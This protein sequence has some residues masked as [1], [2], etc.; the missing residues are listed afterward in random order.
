MIVIPAIDLKDGQC[1]RLKQGDLSDSTVFSD[2]PRET[3]ARWVDAGS[4]RLHIVDLN[5]AVQGRPVNAAAIDAIVDGFPELDIQIGGGIRDAHT[6]GAYLERGVRWVIVGT[7]AVRD[8][9][10]VTAL[11]REFPGHIIVGLDARDGAVATDGW[12]EVS[13]IDVRDLARQFSDSGVSAIVYTDIARDGML[14][15]ANVAATRALA[16]VTDIPV[17][18]SGGVRDLGDIE[19]LCQRDAGAS[20]IH[21]VI[22]GRSIYEGTLNLAQAQALA[23]RLSGENSSPVGTS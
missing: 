2:D 18:A 20:A 10:A 17:I 21:G 7:L 13:G 14:E 22:V 19:A 11:C 1:V 23:A 4:A 15:G 9:A 5:G 6:A 12:V 16:Q 8:P 3:A